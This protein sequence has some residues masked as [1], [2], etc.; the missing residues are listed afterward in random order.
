MRD[1]ESTLAAIMF[2][3]ARGKVFGPA[4]IMMLGSVDGS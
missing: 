1:G 2:L 4:D 3:Q